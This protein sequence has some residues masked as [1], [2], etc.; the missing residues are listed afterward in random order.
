MMQVKSNTL[1]KMAV[2]ACLFIAIA[3][4]VKSC[5]S[6]SQPAATQTGD[7]VV[8]DLTQ[9]ELKALGVE[10]DTPQDTLRTLVGR[11]RTIQNKQVEL[12][13]DNK[14]LAEENARLAQGESGLDNRISAA[15][16]K[17]QKEAE[18]KAEGVKE[19]QRQLSKA[20]DE[21]KERLL[22]GGAGGS[23]AGANGDLPVGLGLG[24]GDEPPAPA[25][26]EGMVWIEPQDAMQMSRDGK[27][28]LADVSASGTG[29]ALQ[30]PSRFS[31]LEDNE[32]TRQKAELARNAKNE[33]GIE[34]AATPVYTLPE[35]STLV[36]SQAMTAL[37]GRVPI[38]GKVTD[39]YPFK[40][41]IGKDNLTANGIQLPDVEGAIVSGTATGDWTLSCVRG[42]V[43]S[44]TFVF[45]DG[46][47]RTV[48]SPAKSTDGSDNKNRSGGSI[49]WLSDEHGV[50]C[51]AGERKSNAS[52]YLPTL[53]ALSGATAAAEAMAEGEMTSSTEG[54]DVTR[55]LT[56]D[57]GT[58]A[59]GKAVSG[60]MQETTNWVRQRY[61]QTFDAI[62]V[63][64]GLRVA[65]HI[66]RQLP[67][68]YEEQGRRV[69][70]DAA[71]GP[72]Q[73]LD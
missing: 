60:G 56:G 33:R 7:S 49:G 26:G 24:A 63:P 25:S 22:N 27:M 23:S 28:T 71:V 6:R 35:N 17:A 12:D 5:G 61:G 20:L 65:V 69:K 52:T 15:V 53:F 9:E 54:T 13:R 8:A 58:Y 19:E 62:Y 18:Q 40:V 16:A 70:Y 45:S 29:G 3:I 66:N 10:G 44:I 34:D 1:L 41:L 30:F 32:I 2:P 39:P 47:V 48:P 68:D 64:P 67:I 51:L 14:A 46:T 55:T 4:G 57:A 59:L 11:M 21:L 37:L 43:Q 31:S 50:P 42:D 72:Q 36:G 73:H 38:D